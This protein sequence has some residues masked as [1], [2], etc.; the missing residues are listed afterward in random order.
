[1]DYY[2][3]AKGQL[4][5]E[6]ALLMLDERVNVIKQS[7]LGKLDEEIAMR[8]FIDRLPHADVAAIVGR[9]RSTVSRRLQK[10]ITPQVRRTAARYSKLPQ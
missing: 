7:G 4:P 5:C 3:V 8:Y 1:M 10:T 2:S 6:L 9:E